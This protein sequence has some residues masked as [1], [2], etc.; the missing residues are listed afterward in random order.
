MV[1][2]LGTLLVAVEARAGDG[3]PLLVFDASAAALP[4]AEIRTAV[5]R[6]LGRPLATTSAEA[7]GE[8][9]VRVDAEHRLVV[10]YRTA[11]GSIDRYLPMP[12]EPADV[13]LIIALAAGNLARD[14]TAGVGPA[15][16]VEPAPAP[17]VTPAP[18]DDSAAQAP[19]PAAATFRRHWLGIHVAQDIAIVGGSNVCDANLGQLSDNYACFY[20]GT[21]DEPFWHTPYPYTDGIGTGPV[22]ATT[23]LLVSY[24]YA[25]TRHLSFGTRLGYAFRG[26]PPAGQTPQSPYDSESNL[27]NLPAHTKGEGG[28]AFLPAHVELRVTGWVIPLDKPLSAFVGAGFGLA[29]VDA[30]TTVPER[31]CA[32]TLDP[33]WDPA[34]GS[35]E[36]C[37]TGSQDFNSQ[38]LSVTEIDAWKKMGQGFVALSLG[39]MLKLVGD[40]RLL[41]NVNAMYMLPAA[42]VVL[43]PSLGAVVGLR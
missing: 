7:S 12:N 35:F 36:Q 4:Q 43:E 27:N 37:R 2:L 23:R 41:L 9:S 8:L 24:D 6:E 38:A 5:E 18:R 11:R 22:L 13:S 19:P 26:G 40:T 34:S 32:E 42:G 30:K 14:P 3:G 29:Q 31:D 15:P 16:R 28:T 17:P 10:R 1:L 21:D 20:E 39:G 25:V 33:G